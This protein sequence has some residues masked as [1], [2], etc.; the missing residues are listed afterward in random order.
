MPRVPF[1]GPTSIQ[2]LL[3]DRSRF[4][5]RGARAWARTNR[6]DTV[7]LELNTETIHVRQ[8]D[9]AEAV[10]GTFRTIHLTDGVQA[11][12]AVHTKDAGKGAGLRRGARAP[13]RPGPRAPVGPPLTVADA[14]GARYFTRDAL[15]QVQDEASGRSRAAVVAMA[16]DLFLRLAE[17]GYDPDK[18]ARVA[19]VLAESGAFNSVPFLRFNKQD[20][21]AIR[22][23]GHEGRHRARA[24]AA[25][26]VQYMP[27]RVVLDDSVRVRWSVN[28]HEVPAWVATEDGG[29]TITARE[30]FGALVLPQG[31]STRVKALRRTAR[32]EIAGGSNRSAVEI[33]DKILVVAERADPQLV[34]WMV[35]RRVVLLGAIEEVLAERRQEAAPSLE[36]EVARVV[37]EMIPGAESRLTQRDPPAF[38]IDMPE[39]WSASLAW[40]GDPAA[41]EARRIWTLHFRG[42]VSRHQGMPDA[43]R[44]L[45][46]A[47]ALD[48]DV[49]P[50]DVSN[51]AELG[52]S[53][54]SSVRDLLAA[55]Q[56]RVDRVFRGLFAGRLDLTEDSTILDAAWHL[57][58]APAVSGWL[59]RRGYDSAGG[60][61]VTEAWNRWPDANRPD[62]PDPFGIPEE[63][64]QKGTHS[65]DIGKSEGMLA[66]VLG[67]QAPDL[68]P[69]HVEAKR[70]SSIGDWQASVK[71]LKARPGVASVSALGHGKTRTAAMRDAVGSRSLWQA[72]WRYRLAPYFGE[73]DDP[74]AKLKVALAPGGKERP[75]GPASGTTLGHIGL[76]QVQYE[77]VTVV[78]VAGSATG[79]VG[80]P[81]A[82]QLT[83]GD[84]TVSVWIG[85]ADGVVVHPDDEALWTELVSD[86]GGA[87][88]GV[89]RM[90]TSDVIS[91]LSVG[92]TAANDA[93]ST[94]DAAVA[95]VAEYRALADAKAD[96]VQLVA[97]DARARI[98]VA[99]GVEAASAAYT[100]DSL[101]SA[102]FAA[103]KRAGLPA[104]T[105][106]PP[107][108]LTKGS[109]PS[110][111]QGSA[112]L[113]DL[114]QGS[115]RA[116]FV[117][118]RKDGA[119]DGEGV[120]LLGPYDTHEAALADVNRGTLLVHRF[121]GGDP[122]A[123]FAG[124]GTAQA[125]RDAVSVFTMAGELNPAWEARVAKAPAP[126]PAPAESSDQLGWAQVIAQQ[127]AE[128]LDKLNTLPANESG[129]RRETERDVLTLADQLASAAADIPGAAGEE[130]RR[131]AEDGDSGPLVEYLLSL[132]AADGGHPGPAAASVP[133]SHPGAP[134]L[135]GG[136]GSKLGSKGLAQAV[137][138][139]LPPERAWTA[140]HGGHD[141]EPLVRA[142]TGTVVVVR[143]PDG[144]DRR[145]TKQREADGPDSNV[146]HHPDTGA[147]ASND[148]GTYTVAAP[149]SES[150]SKLHPLGI[151][152]S[153]SSDLVTVDSDDVRWTWSWPTNGRTYLF[154]AW[155][156]ATADYG[157][158]VG[159]GTVEDPA[160]RKRALKRAADLREV[161]VS[162]PR[163]G[164]LASGLDKLVVAGGLESRS[165]VLAVIATEHEGGQDAQYVQLNAH[166]L[167]P[168][169]RE[170]IADAAE[171]VVKGAGDEYRGWVNEMGF[172]GHT[173][174]LAGPI[175]IFV[176]L[177][178]QQ[179]AY[180]VA[181]GFRATQT[182]TG[183]DLGAVL[184][185]ALKHYH[186]RV[187]EPPSPGL[188]EDLTRRVG[189]DRK[190]SILYSP[191]TAAWS[192]PQPADKPGDKSRDAPGSSRAATYRDLFHF[193]YTGYISRYTHEVA[194]AFGLD[195][196]AAYNLLRKLEAHPSREPDTWM[197]TA[198][199]S[200]DVGVGTRG[201][202]RD[203]GGAK[204]VG[205]DLLW[206]FQ[207]TGDSAKWS[208]V[209]AML[210]REPLASQPVP[211]ATWN[212]YAKVDIAP[213]ASP[214]PTLEDVRARKIYPWIAPVL[215][216]AEQLLGVR[217]VR[218]A[219]L[220]QGA[221]GQVFAVEGD[222]TRVVKITAEEKEVRGLLRLAS[223]AP[224][225]GVRV[226]MVV[227]LGPTTRRPDYPGDPVE[228]YAILREAV[229]PLSDTEAESMM[230]TWTGPKVERGEVLNIAKSLGHSLIDY[231]RPPES[232]IRRGWTPS[233]GKAL[234][235]YWWADNA[236]WA[237]NYFMHQPD[238]G[239]TAKRRLQALTEYR[240]W[241][242]YAFGRYSDNGN[243]HMLVALYNASHGGGET[244]QGAFSDFGLGNI[245]R[246]SRG[247]L[248]W[249]DVH[250]IDLN[251]TGLK[252]PQFIVI[253]PEVPPQ[254]GDI[255][256]PEGWT[257]RE[258]VWHE[259]DPDAPVG[260]AGKVTPHRRFAWSKGRVSVFLDWPGTKVS[261]DRFGVSVV[262]NGEEYIPKG[263]RLTTFEIARD[264][265]V[266]VMAD[267]SGPK[268]AAPQGDGAATPEGFTERG[269]V[270][271]MTA[272]F[273]RMSA[274]ARQYNRTLVTASG[275][276]V[277]KVGVA[278]PDTYYSAMAGSSSN[279][280]SEPTAGIEHRTGLLLDQRGGN[281]SANPVRLRLQARRVRRVQPRGGYIGDWVELPAGTGVVRDVTFLAGEGPQL[282]V[283]RDGISGHVWAY[284]MANVVLPP[285]GWVGLAH[286]AEPEGAEAAGEVWAEVE[287]RTA[288]KATADAAFP[289]LPSGR[290]AST[291]WKL[292]A[293]HRAQGEFWNSPEVAKIAQPNGR[294]VSVRLFA[295]VPARLA[296]EGMGNNAQI[297]RVD[298]RNI[299]AEHLTWLE[300]KTAREV[301][302]GLH[303]AVSTVTP[304]EGAEP[305][306]LAGPYPGSSPATEEYTAAIAKLMQGL[307]K[308][309]GASS[310][311]QNYK[312]TGR[313]SA[314]RQIW[315]NF[316]DGSVI[317]IW[318]NHTN[319][320][321]GGV[322][323]RRGGGEGGGRIRAVTYN[324][325]SPEE[326][327]ADIEA[328]LAGWL[329]LAPPKPANRVPA[330][331]PTPT[332]PPAAAPADGPWG[333][334]IPLDRRSGTY[335]RIVRVEPPAPNL[336][337][338]TQWYSKRGNAERAWELAG[339][340]PEAVAHAET[341]TWAAG[342]RI[343]HLNER[344]PAPH[345]AVAGAAA[346]SD[347]CIDVT[348]QLGSRQIRV[349]CAQRQKRTDVVWHN[350]WIDGVRH[351][352]N[353]SRWARGAVPPPD[354][355]DAVRARGIS[356][357]D[358]EPL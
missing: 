132:G 103:Q 183:G 12:V 97:A 222:P 111:S 90:R 81:D 11:I 316:E 270:H 109:G 95:V 212:P 224:N 171:R 300:N 229:T 308:T 324:G 211:G 66:D 190:A 49:P 159:T 65:R 192:S 174:I 269:S 264:H 128:A 37:Q 317:D 250:W 293:S 289:V 228:G 236:A 41:P 102:L 296:Q 161:E 21:M 259:H 340:A 56:P 349:V 175:P 241:L 23:I 329:G 238:G 328:V 27:V 265:A 91:F 126:T 118:A 243:P 202:R 273:E 191:A 36:A 297:H 323:S 223:R 261:P 88:R 303:T 139:A 354:V 299:G 321:F 83:V 38:I 208:E 313:E 266:S 130:A 198:Q 54:A 355:L 117:S 18:T 19:G 225:R 48:A 137:P 220:G 31:D 100:V 294:E 142:P 342:E 57:Y 203:P 356:A 140:G 85:L 290:D 69:W 306:A 101:R 334:T 239:T 255:A 210:N 319:V 10:A 206:I 94:Y 258:V 173:D 26:G 106:L 219:A 7:P 182:A 164:P 248:V 2:S 295:G 167:T 240:G 15:A 184:V 6:F 129:K 68:D 170:A 39:R 152:D 327:F 298:L 215:D 331:L 214:P 172:D 218:D 249:F 112:Q 199:Q 92:A 24:L 278:G 263:P 260:V 62:L 275:D 305:A 116:Y 64:W 53:S 67:R 120:L 3:F 47:L 227:A 279:V 318:L 315:T 124:F 28:P 209:E 267:H 22:V 233:R 257:G 73:G 314:R 283:E 153:G 84:Q 230:L 205:E 335:V 134:L 187:A 143:G 107:G 291:Y 44:H 213:P 125:P 268:A 245:G 357:F 144:V 253:G 193:L 188:V 312:G 311:R 87:T 287:A 195:K 135:P 52:L 353:G 14:D 247:G 20:A 338:P 99:A 17:R 29:E 131:L 332:A 146:W 162:I 301:R 197:L 72:I 196:R 343:A 168:A 46:G 149:A 32:A 80:H 309:V 151:V 330:R 237:L 181:N 40:V 115:E 98:A 9:P 189:I 358:G 320:E 271:P 276:L 282:H 284:K 307:K 337:A 341:V 232:E 333:P 60:S 177:G 127:L 244:P 272:A 13:V 70:T 96:P 207:P 42:D 235:P 138:G 285:E 104:S 234:P 351:G 123:A 347:D 200:T 82:L 114:S 4:D 50:A 86:R 256:V 348:F 157:R 344:W 292:L 122:H 148:L 145:F 242:K 179:G 89:V 158:K 277:L 51:I 286:V 63:D 93:P 226:D 204:V 33:Y 110:P 136:A 231:E 346:P 326:V 154:G 5:P 339:A 156:V 201:Q 78:R 77:R 254:I 108:A 251:P 76:A 352:F 336:D 325:R 221:N 16:P 119:R 147:V 194:E 165:R 59:A 246:N 150:H 185:K 79:A 155:S 71:S 281:A 288:A 61:F 8:W 25:L 169:E 74:L 160:A 216:R 280:R 55:A 121:F 304:G 322:V 176:E 262:A 133:G 252:L 1:S 105:A 141:P 113:K 30:V 302:A 35:T 45:A 34:A 310:L 75:R 166:V 350:I 178:G 217:L 43:I 345:R 180:I 58:G 186:D 163:A 274:A